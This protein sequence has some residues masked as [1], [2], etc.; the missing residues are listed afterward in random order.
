[1]VELATHLLCLNERTQCI[2]LLDSLLRFEVDHARRDLWGDFGTATL[3]RAYLH[4]LCD[5]EELR[6]D[7]IKE[8][9]DDDIV[10]RRLTRSQRLASVM[11]D[12]EEFVAIADRCSRRDLQ[13]SFA[14]LFMKFLHLHEIIL[15]DPGDIKP[16]ERQ[17]ITRMLEEIDL[18]L[19]GV[20]LP[21]A[22][23][24]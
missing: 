16:D 9:Y 13:R 19:R 8:V 1:M 14:Y 7:R 22:V 12:Y 5:E 18:N 24:A 2:E 10:S 15:L 6:L 20:L 11:E 23:R 4:H 17:T 3:L 21:H